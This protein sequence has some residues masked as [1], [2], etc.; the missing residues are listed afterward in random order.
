MRDESVGPS[1]TWAAL[2]GAT[3]GGA[4][5]V[6]YAA[7]CPAAQVWGRGFYRGG[8]AGRELALTFDDGP[9]NETPAFLDL[10]ARYDIR[11]TFFVCGRN[12]ERRPETARRVLAAGHEVG[13]HT[14]SHP[15]LLRLPPWRVRREV[16]TAQRIL[17]DRLGVRPALFRAPYGVHAPGLRAALEL[18]ELTAVRWTVIGNDWRW[19]APAIARRVLRGASPGGVICLH[20]GRETFPSADRQNTL[21]ALETILPILLAEGYRFVTASEMRETLVK[22]L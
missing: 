8:A 4:A 14:D 10:L 13:N 2:A 9:S 21:A 7:V 18:E 11:G 6:A 17:E 1:R 3:L 15:L 12:V 19:P 22:A 20:D 16:E 5:A